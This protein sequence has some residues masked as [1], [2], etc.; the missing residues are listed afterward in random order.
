[1]MFALVVYLVVS[2]KLFIL[3]VLDLQPVLPKLHDATDL[4]D[5]RLF[6][7]DDLVRLCKTELEV[8]TSETREEEPGSFALQGILHHRYI[9]H[10]STKCGT[11][12][13]RSYF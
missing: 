1:M 11:F 4:G 2:N 9:C 8:E 13:P 7:R 3:L 6:L 5:P 12:S 10:V